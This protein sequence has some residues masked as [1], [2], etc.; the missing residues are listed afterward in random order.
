MNRATCPSGSAIREFALAI[1]QG[2]Y[3]RFG[4]SV[5]HECPVYPAYGISFFDR[6][7]Y[8]DH[9]VGLDR[10]V[11]A[12]FQLSLTSTCMVDQ[13]ATQTVAGRTTLPHTKLDKPHL[14]GMYFDAQ[15]TAVLAGHSPFYIPDDV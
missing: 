10:L 8:E 15:L 7:G 3:F 9:S 4:Q 13:H 1:E 11:F 14:A 6:A 5:F 12:R 2:R